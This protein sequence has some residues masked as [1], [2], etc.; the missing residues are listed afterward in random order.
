MFFFSVRDI[1]VDPA[2]LSWKL[3]L[4]VQKIKNKFNRDINL[5]EKL[6]HATQIHL[7]SKLKFPMSS[8]GCFSNF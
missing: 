5:P 4:P 3:R 6:V 7:E 8:R 1:F 2:R